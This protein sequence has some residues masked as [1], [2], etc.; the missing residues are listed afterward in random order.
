MYY[1]DGVY[2]ITKF[3]P[4]HPG[5]KD[6]ILLAAGK[7]IQPFWNV[8]RQHYNSKLPMELLEDMR[9]GTLHPDD[10]AAA[11][12][13]ADNSDPYSKDPVLSPL[14]T[15]IQRKPINAEPPNFIL[16]DSWITATDAWFVRN[17]HPVPLIDEKDFRL[18]LDVGIA[19][20]GSSHAYTLDDLKKKFK[21]H[22]V[23]AAIQCGGNRRAEMNRRLTTLGSPWGVG[24]I[25]NGKWTGVL[26]RDV[27]LSA[28]VTDDS[29]DERVNPGNRVRH[30]VFVGEDGMEASVPVRTAMDRYGDVLLA[31]EMNDKPLTSQHG[32]PLRVVVPG[33][34]GVR[35]AKWL[36]EVRL[37]D[38]EAKG[39]WQRGI[40]YK[41]CVRCSDLTF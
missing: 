25:S 20:G 31:Y 22:T 33:H 32:Y 39:P 21:P 29:V 19:T 16:T 26:L 7:D 5:G 17:H 12:K 38:E 3:V 9:I 11:A 15:Y 34:V 37:S 14:M 35:N 23:V 27:L 40:A 36:K 28:G 8:Y 10:V 41:V 13:S 2:D 18:S 1:K 24:A 30:V 6:K 4:N